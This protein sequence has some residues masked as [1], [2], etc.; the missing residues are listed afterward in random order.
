MVPG[1]ARQPSRVMRITNAQGH[2]FTGQ[3]SGTGNRRSVAIDGIIVEER[4]QPDLSDVEGSNQIAA[5][6]CRMGPEEELTSGVVGG[7]AIPE[8]R[9]EPVIEQSLRRLARLPGICV[10]RLRCGRSG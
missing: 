5:T 8:T 7:G 4:A 6:D 9:V 3:P 1:E 10:S 2:S